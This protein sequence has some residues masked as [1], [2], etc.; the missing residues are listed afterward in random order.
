MNS[1]TE[2]SAGTAPDY[3]TTFPADRKDSGYV[4]LAILLSHRVG[5]REAESQGKRP[6]LAANAKSGLSR[7]Y[8]RRLRARELPDHRRITLNL[9]LGGAGT[10]GDGGRNHRGKS[11]WQLGAERAGLDI[12][13]RIYQRRYCENIRIAP[14]IFFCR[15]LDASSSC[16]IIIIVK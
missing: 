16:F 3:S 12:G 15:V 1:T 9:D 13:S 10:D 7:F 2:T 14:E 4:L 11:R 5:E 8:L 6:H